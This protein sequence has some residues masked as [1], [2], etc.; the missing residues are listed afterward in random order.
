MTR[1]AISSTHKAVQLYYRTLEDYAKEN[2]HH[3]TAVRSA[4]QNLL[5]D[6]A[7]MHGW[8]LIPEL[9]ERSSR[10]VWQHN[11]GQATIAT[12]RKSVSAG[13]TRCSLRGGHPGPFAQVALTCRT[14][15][16]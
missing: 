9:G 7:R 3:E 4:F 11:R 1:G 14:A 5:A 16:Y 10:L 8:L 6:T 2:I 12:T 15:P 13:L